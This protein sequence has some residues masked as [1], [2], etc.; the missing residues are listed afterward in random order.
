M[1]IPDRPQTLSILFQSL[2]QDKPLPEPEWGAEVQRCLGT[3]FLLVSRICLSLIAAQKLVSGLAEE[4]EVT[5]ISEVSIT[6]TAAI[7]IRFSTSVMFVL[8]SFH[9]HYV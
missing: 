9:R 2:E 6:I 5:I 3:G 8:I 4:N 1:C 7:E